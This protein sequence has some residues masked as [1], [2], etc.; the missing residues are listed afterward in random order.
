MSIA[1]RTAMAGLLG[2]TLAQAPA[3]A[4]A[5]QPPLWV[6][7]DADSTVYMVGTVHV[8]R[9]GMDWRSTALARAVAEAE[10]LW[11]EIPHLEAS[12]DLQAL[13]MQ[14]GLSP[15]T[16][17]SSL[18]T[19]AELAQL[20]IIL[21]RHEVALDD[22]DAFRPWLAYIQI[23]F[24]PLVQSGFDPENGLDVQIKAQADER[25]IPVHGF[26]TLEGQFGM[27]SGLPEQVQLDVLRH[28]IVNFEDIQ[29]DLRIQLDSW[30]DGDLAPLEAENTKIAAELPEFYEVFFA[31]R[32]AGFV[33]G[34]E[35]ILAG[36]GTVLVAVGLGH[37][38][39]PES[40]PALLAERGHAVERR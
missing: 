38:A 18:L 13:V 36:S 5:P 3:L 28:T 9:E 23:S 19:E 6:V 29:A 11:L 4:Q 15:D 22:F 7:R 14:T 32:N 17:L 1:T 33:D 12:E 8:M 34:I 2:W 40:I 26:E 31:G 20:E 16:P 37:F 30:I 39:G 35:Q 10:A 24:L 21:N 27:L 25:G